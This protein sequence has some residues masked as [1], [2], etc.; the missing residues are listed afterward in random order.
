MPRVK[1]ISFQ[2]EITQST[3]RKFISFQSEKNH[4]KSKIHLISIRN[5]TC[6]VWKSLISIRNQTIYG[7]KIYFISIRNAKCKIHLISEWKSAPFNQNSHMSRVKI[8]SFQSQTTRAQSETHL[9]SIN[10]KSHNLTRVKI[11]SINQKTQNTQSKIHLITI[12]NHTWKK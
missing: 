11:I 5:H 1:I 8:I 9:I 2:S 7:L 3:D 6:P 4:A 10:Q 12:R